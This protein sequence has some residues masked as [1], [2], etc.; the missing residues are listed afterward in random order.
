MVG[1]LCLAAGMAG[2]AC[3]QEAQAEV[4]KESWTDHVK[5]KG[6]VRLRYENIDK[7]GSPSRSRERYR[8][9]L[10]VEG[11][12]NDEIKAGIGFRTG[13]KDPISG[14]QTM[15]DGFTSKDIALELA[16][17]DWKPEIV[18]GVSLVG[19]KMQ[20][21][22][23]EVSDL[24]WDGDLNPEGGA[25]RYQLQA[26][27]ATLLANGAAL[28]VTERS[29]DS[30][31]MI[32]AGQAGVDLK[33]GAGLTVLAGVGYYFY[34]NMKDYGVIDWE[35]SFNSFGN[36]AVKTTDADGNVTKSVYANDYREL[37][38]M[39]AIGFK[40]PLTGL[41]WKFYG[42]FV[43]N[44]EADDNDTGYLAGVKLGKASKPRSFEIGYNYRRLEA[45]AVVGAFSDSDS[46][47]GGTDGKG[48]KIKAAYQI[49]KNWTL[50][51][52]YFV[53]ELGIKD[54]EAAKDYKRFQLDLAAK[55]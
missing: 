33:T 16:Y 21:P 13:G 25:V 8:A 14:N 11:K 27:P 55:F 43:R 22:F 51:A 28:A 24:V 32:Y 2:L 20:K 30:D 29:K 23:M 10:G 45:D 48:H 3:G 15:G 31:T 26:G 5:V 1:V 54:G 18:P 50:G 39:A 42:N 4:K 53:D 40:C 35:D 38:F 9:R 41:P 44:T 49:A 46:W 17:V 19:G 36:T 12:V 37:E 34:D 7:E 47:G 52:T 6:D